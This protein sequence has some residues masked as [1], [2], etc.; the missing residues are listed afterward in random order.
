MH[1]WMENVEASKKEDLKQDAENHLTKRRS[2][3]GES[4]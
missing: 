3:C 4:L 1:A 2:K